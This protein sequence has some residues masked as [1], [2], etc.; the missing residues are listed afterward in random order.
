M[1]KENK[2]EDLEALRHSTEHILT[3]AMLK[4]YPGIKM[5]MGPAIENGFY[6]DF[7]YDDPSTD[8][9][10]PTSTSSVFALSKRSASK[11]SPQAGSRQAHKI[12]EEDFPKIEAEMKKIIKE[13][14]PFRKEEMEVS[15][16]K[17]LF[18]DNP[19]KQEWLN[20]IEARGEK[21][22]L[23]WTDQAFVDLC[24]GP[25]V[26]ST[27]EIKAFKLLSIAGAYWRG[28]EKNKMLVRL[29][30][31]AFDSQ[32][33]LDEYLH[34]L[35]EAKKRDHRKIAQEQELFFIDEEFGKGLP[36]W[37]PKGAIL[38]QL[39]MDFA[40]KSYFAKGYQLV[41]T[42]HIANKILW[43][44]SGHW[45]F[46][47][48]S[49]YSPM[50]IDE[51]EF[52][53][54]PMNCPGH[55]KIYNFKLRSYRDLPL[56]FTEM[57]TV[58]RYEK[59]GELSGLTRVRGFT[60]DDAHIFC[61]PE[62]LQD[63]LIETIGLTRYILGTF[64]FKDVKISLSVR[65]PNNK[66]K[67]LGSDETWQLAEKALEEALKKEKLSFER[68]E[69]EATFYGPKIDV[70]VRDAIG[71]K[72]QLSTIQV[73]FNF[74][75]KFDMNYIDKNG[76]KQRPIMIHRALLGSLERFIGVLIEHCAGAFP[77][78]LSPEQIWV[79]PIS[80]DHE[81]YAR[82]VNETLQEKGFRSFLKNESGTINKKIREGEI[83]R[84]PYLLVVGDKEIKSKS[85]AVRERG[86]KKVTVLKL[87]E[88]INKAEKE[89]T[90]K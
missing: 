55:V 88:F 11:G 59:S 65:D 6:F 53:I 47:R 43:E 46:Y 17:K 57:G 67:Y 87:D 39:I 3:Q 89:N 66:D 71:R 84:I 7:Q 37:L 40:L 56:K 90:Q 61:T 10:S 21:A 45:N 12:S 64:G 22:T 49:M 18:T 85:V 16:A 86:K 79:I 13:N 26:K 35:E 76:Q 83:G 78:W 62:Q 27:G 23:Y 44:R 74:P 15:E 72:H 54:K 69:G 20:E 81:K 19:Y 82:K 50:Q 2:K 32:K 34:Q 8:S 25:H 52:V 29:Y 42:P 68:F 41:A 73:D 30:G 31:T 24:A 48:G 14:L 38:R 77:F 51:E 4:L 1:A 75:Q 33:D 63:I 5:A 80:Q 28:D 70:L 60:Q 9:A 58:Y 36:L